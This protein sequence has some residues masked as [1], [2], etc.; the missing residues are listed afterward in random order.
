MKTRVHV[1]RG[2]TVVVIAGKDRGKKGKVTAVVPDKGRVKVEGVNM[3]TKHQKP[4]AKVMQGGLVKQE[5]LIA[6]SNVMLVC[7]RCGSPARTRSK[8]L[9]GGNRVRSCGKCEEVIDK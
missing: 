7:P 5:G 3:V 4:N 8:E 9:T 6:S 2:D 1:R